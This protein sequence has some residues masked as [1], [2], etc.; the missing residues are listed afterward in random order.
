[1]YKYNSYF[2]NPSAIGIAESTIPLLTLGVPLSCKI[3]RET[4]LYSLRHVLK[5]TLGFLTY[6]SGSQAQF[7]T[8]FSHLIMQSVHALLSNFPQDMPRCTTGHNPIKAQ[9][10]YRLDQLDDLFREFGV[11]EGGMPIER[12]YY[13]ASCLFLVF[14]PNGRGCG[15]SHYDY[16]EGEP[17]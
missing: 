8:H 15:N 2:Q 11:K 3:C 16:F 1:M 5:N 10:F 6:Y 17:R 9:Q 12:A 14:G 4:A 13:R 7:A